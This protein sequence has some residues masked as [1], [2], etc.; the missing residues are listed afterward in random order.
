MT[1]ISKDGRQ[2]RMTKTEIIKEIGED[3]TFVKDTNVW[4]IDTTIKYTK[5]HS[6]ADVR[7]GLNRL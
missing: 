2:W 4:E 1:I 7:A 5:R 6:G 3:I